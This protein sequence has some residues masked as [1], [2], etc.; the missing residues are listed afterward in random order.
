MR[1]WLGVTYSFTHTHFKLLVASNISCDKDSWYQ[2][3][4]QLS[5]Q[6]SVHPFI[7]T[8][9]QFISITFTCI[10]IDL[11]IFI[12]QG[13]IDSIIIWPYHSS[14]YIHLHLIFLHKY[15]SPA[16][17]NIHP[18][19][20]VIYTRNY[21]SMCIRFNFSKRYLLVHRDLFLPTSS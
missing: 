17:V 10:H 18:H 8:R 15:Y 3:S 16:P 9:N 13:N 7:F 21:F 2:Y 6:L 19:H 20:L 1:I 4:L 12:C 11:H 14:S 5:N